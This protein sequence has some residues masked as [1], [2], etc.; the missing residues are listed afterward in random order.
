MIDVY[1]KLDVTE[2]G[3]FTYEIVIP[4]KRS[5][6]TY[7]IYGFNQI[8]VLSLVKDETFLSPS[9]LIQYFNEN[10]TWINRDIQHCFYKG[11]V[12]ENQLSI[13][14]ISLCNGLVS[15]VRLNC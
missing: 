2:Q 7:Q 8:F 10:Q 14:S 11:Y 5:S 1:F 9:F 15:I 3:R 4:Q 12:N 13:V 6:G